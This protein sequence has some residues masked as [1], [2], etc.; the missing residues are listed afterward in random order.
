MRRTRRES[1]TDRHV[2]GHTPY[3]DV[4]NAPHPNHPPSKV[5]YTPEHYHTC[6]ELDENV[7]VIRQ[8]MTAPFAEAVPSSAYLLEVLLALCAVFALAATI[9]KQGPKAVVQKCGVRLQRV[10]RAIR[11]VERKMF[12]ICL[13]LA[14]LVQ[15]S[16]LHIGWDNRDCKKLVWTIALMTCS[17]DVLR[18]NV[19]M[20][21]QFLES[22]G[23]KRIMRAHETSQLTGGFYMG[24]GVACTMTISPPSIATAALLFLVMGDMT[25][26][27]IGVSFGGEVA[28][29]KLGR[30]GK[31]SLEGSLAMFF[32]CVAVGCITFAGVELREYP[33]FWGALAATL[34][35]LYEPLGLND[36]LTIPVIASLAMQWGF[37]RIS[38]CHGGSGLDALLGQGE[39]ALDGA[40][41]WA[42]D[43]W[44]M[45]GIGE[46]LAGAPP[47][48]PPPAKIFGLF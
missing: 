39:I 45:V 41:G 44:E 38:H 15:N 48:P 47:P 42:H 21:W 20:I 11:E 8:R 13:L 35:E 32:V 16:L 27:I 43:A 33:V 19:P 26:A 37:A 18:L 40:R 30:A 9:F 14:P 28:V 34:T 10:A 7:A 3:K 23:A 31:K 46:L 29:V 6:G 1:V 36:N 24:L 5:R 2:Q 12:H 17:V 4:G 22:V 25:A